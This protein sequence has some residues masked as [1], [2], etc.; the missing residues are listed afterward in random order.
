MRKEWMKR[1][2]KREG[3]RPQIILILMA[4]CIMILGMAA[5]RIYID[6]VENWDERVTNV[7]KGTLTIEGVSPIASNPERDYGKNIFVNVAENEKFILG[8]NFATGEVSVTEKTTGK[9]WYSN[10]SGRTEADVAKMNGKL[11]A[12]LILKCL[13]K[14]NAY[15][16]EVNNFA[17]SI[18]LGGMDYELVDNGIK[19]VFSFPNVGVRVPVQYCLCEDGITAEILNDEIEE[20]WDEEYLL[21]QVTLLPYFGAGGLDDNGY[22]FV[23]DGSG[24]LINF[25]NDKQKGPEYNASI[26]GLDLAFAIDDSI[27]LRQSASLPV[28]GLKSNQNAFLAV[29]DSGESCGTIF[30][31]I[32]K[33]NNPYNMAYSTV[34]YREFRA[35]ELDPLAISAGTR[36]G[37]DYSEMLLKEE[38]YRIKYI[39]LEEESADY[40]GMSRVYKEY[41]TEQEL[42]K[43][44]E[45]AGENY[46]ILDIYGAVSIEKYVL[47][48]ERSVITPLTTYNEVCDIVRELKSQG[49]ENLIVN[50]IGALDS[51]FENKVYDE[52]K[53]EKCLG[54]KKDFKNMINYLNEEDVLLFIES[55]PICIYKDGNGYSMKGDSIKTLFDGY[56]FQYNYTRNNNDA[57]VEERWNLMSPNLAA[58]QMVMFSDTAISQGVSNLSVA[59][60]GNTLYSNMRQGIGYATRSESKK[61]YMEALQTVDQNT[62]YLMV[63]NGNAYCLPYTDVVTDVADSSSAYD[64]EDHSIPFYQLVLSGKVLIGTN[65]INGSSDSHYGFLK[66]METGSCL[67]FN[68][69]FSDVTELV[70]TRYDD[71]A[72]FSYDQWKDVIVEQYLAKQEIVKQLG[73]QVIVA[74]EELAEDVFMTVYESGKAV[75]VNYSEE[76]YVHGNVVIEGNAYSLIEERKNE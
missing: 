48:V 26:Y 38:N 62:D 64:I 65:A 70:G 17:D 45:L 29:I 30:A 27:S 9:I 55:N 40:V 22:L 75:I 16:M 61:L 15:S 31:S 28:Y 32:S 4:A 24:A 56:V 37:M 53:Y 14:K 51:G 10:P 57:I 36:A 58:K 44:T 52:L 21:L 2:K 49:V 42:A 47:G 50:Y 19:F 3:F 72:F 54:S 68:T 33:M 39:F 12:Q 71:L 7:R 46:L 18:K 1:D 76:R 6:D 43:T 11:S 34:T 13:E 8:A 63:H 67:K 74:H 60:V 69:V 25:N 23:P 20:L 35:T 5:Y 73:G 66:S 41:L 59:G